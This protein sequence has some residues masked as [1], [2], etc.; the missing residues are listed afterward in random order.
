MEEGS[1]MMEWVARLRR[2]LHPRPAR[3]WD[4]RNEKSVG[5]GYSCVSNKWS[6]VIAKRQGSS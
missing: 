6:V 1:V 3:E 5:E 2:E 4:E